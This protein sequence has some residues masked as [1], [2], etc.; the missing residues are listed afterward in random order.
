M[1]AFTCSWV[2]VFILFSLAP[3]ASYAGGGGGCTSSG[4]ENTMYG[5][6]IGTTL[7]LIGYLFLQHQG[8]QTDGNEKEAEQDIQ[9][10][11]SL[12]FQNAGSGRA[13][14]EIVVYRW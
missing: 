2:F 5:I 3:S 4:C 8:S 1:K 6:A 11:S 14:P 7:L 13:T 10:T 9:E 12:Q